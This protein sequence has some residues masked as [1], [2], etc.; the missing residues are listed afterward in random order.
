MALARVV[1]ERTSRSARR[2]GSVR[3]RRLREC[4]AFLA[5]DNRLPC[6]ADPRSRSLLRVPRGRSAVG[7]EIRISFRASAP[8]SARGLR[9]L[10][11]V[12]PRVALGRCL[13]G[14]APRRCQTP[15]YGTPRYG[16]RA[17]RRCS[18]PRSVSAEVS[19]E[20]VPTP[21]EG[22]PR[23]CQTPRH[24]HPRHPTSR[25]RS[26]HPSAQS[27]SRNRSPRYTVRARSDSASARGVPS[28]MT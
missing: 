7:A 24:G 12:L 21:R 27:C 11:G 22:A 26:S 17:L 8:S 5:C 6:A 28:S 9:A 1:Q 15:R 4:G 20:G 13:P 19:R 18:D 25:E 16:R 14:G 3:E 10:L 2:S 23:R